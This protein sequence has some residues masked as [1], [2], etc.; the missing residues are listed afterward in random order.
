M[1]KRQSRLMS[2]AP[3]VTALGLAI[4][5]KAVPELLEDGG[6]AFLLLLVSVGLFIWGL[7][8][9]NDSNGLPRFI[10]G[11]VL[12][13]GL[14]FLRYS[15]GALVI[16]YWPFLFV[17][18]ITWSRYFDSRIGPMALS[19]ACN[20]ALVGIMALFSG[21]FA[22]GETEGVGDT[23]ERNL[24]RSAAGARSALWLCAVGVSGSLAASFLPVELRHV[25][26]TVGTIC[27]PLGVIAAWMYFRTEFMHSRKVWGA[28]AILAALPAAVGSAVSGMREGFLKLPLAIVVGYGVARRRLPY[29][30][31]VAVAMVT[32]VIGLPLFNTYKDGVQYGRTRTEIFSQFESADSFRAKSEDT[33]ATTL[34]RG[35]GV[36]FLTAYGQSYDAAFDFEYGHTFYLE[37]AGLIPRVLWPSKPEL[38]AELNEYP[39]KVGILY[40][41]DD[42]TTATFDWIS[43]YY[44]NGGLMGV[45]VLGYL[46]G[47]YLGM[48]RKLIVR[49][50]G[51][52]AGA[53]IM[54]SLL[55]SDH[56]Q[57]GMVLLLV[58]HSRTILVWFIL[59]SVFF[60]AGRVI[61]TTGG[62][63]RIHPIPY[64]QSVLPWSGR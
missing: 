1:T 35:N 58:S 6:M 30:T 49:R 38:S 16:L 63:A 36:V 29:L 11:R 39:K 10:D 43:E 15:M 62:P 8:M 55:I 37:L 34:I 45:V 14:T 46:H 9:A 48:V 44:V 57:F 12:V 4:T 21:L 59:F 18:S 20:M 32:I 56:D 3:V 50:A 64:R 27:A 53:L 7:E 17:D 24:R 33:I 54:F 47:L 26:T 31:I 51:P 40:L 41:E 60:R 25:A 23:V 13:I 5:G 42:G 19:S 22:V 28:I 2:Q 61:A 52:T